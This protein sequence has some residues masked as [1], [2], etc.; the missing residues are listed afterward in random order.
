[1]EV[2]PLSKFCFYLGSLPPRT[3]FYLRAE[4]HRI[5]IKQI[6]FPTLETQGEET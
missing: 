3:L 5:T 1:M 6:L 4:Y 2:G